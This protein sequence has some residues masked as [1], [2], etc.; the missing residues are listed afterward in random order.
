MSTLSSNF[1]NRPSRRMCRAKARQQ[2]NGRNTIILLTIIFSKL[3]DKNKKC[4][5]ILYAVN[6]FGGTHKV[7]A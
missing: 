6:C 7:T 2:T 1:S 3:T 4:N 5:R